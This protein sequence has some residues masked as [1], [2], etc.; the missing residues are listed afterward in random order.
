MENV[1]HEEEGMG[2]GV[3]ELVDNRIDKVMLTW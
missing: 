2:V 3:S 1:E